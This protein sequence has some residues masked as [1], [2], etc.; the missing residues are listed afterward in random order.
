MRRLDPIFHASLALIL[1]F[2]LFQPANAGAFV[3]CRDCDDDPDKCIPCT[4]SGY[5]RIIVDSNQNNIP[6]ESPDDVPLDY[7][8]T[9]KCGSLP[10]DVFF[11]AFWHKERDTVFVYGRGIRPNYLA[12]WGANCLEFEKKIQAGKVVLEQTADS[13]L[14][15]NEMK[16]E[17]GYRDRRRAA[18]PPPGYDLM[19]LE[20]ME[21]GPDSQQRWRAEGFAVDTNSDQKFDRIQGTLDFTKVLK[22]L[23]IDEP[24]K[25]YTHP[26]TGRRYMELPAA[27]VRL[28]NP[29]EPWQDRTGP[30]K[31]FIPVGEKYLDIK[32]GQ[33]F[34]ARFALDTKISG[35]PD[36]A[37]ELIVTVNNKLV[38][39]KWNIVPGA[40]GNILA[41]APILEGGAAGPVGWIDVGSIT[42]G[43]VEV[44]CLTMYV[45]VLP[46]NS[47]GWAPLTALSNVASFSI[48]AWMCRGRGRIAA[49]EVD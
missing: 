42:G 1:F 12:T 5:T 30:Y 39:L 11:E 13:S 3:R 38:T 40:S 2:V 22:A 46:Y 29:T 43:T 6:D 25:I 47:F 28:S 9:V 20:W 48:P 23:V 49:G 17:A 36:I 21:W 34:I 15:W 19:G 10:C 8:S 35:P 18:D 16:V 27:K 41:Y 31:T 7:P 14:S 4:F 37:P 32:C 24:I 33:K 26:K 45:A 44:P